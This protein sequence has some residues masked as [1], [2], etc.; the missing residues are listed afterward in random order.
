MA[1]TAMLQNGVPVANGTV[2][3]SRRNSQF[4]SGNVV[5]NLNLVDWR[6]P[7]SASNATLAFNEDII[8]RVTGHD[9]DGVLNYRKL[10]HASYAV[11]TPDHFMPLPAILG[12]ADG[13]DAEV[14]N[15][16]CNLGSIAMTGFLFA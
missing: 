6:N 4:G 1:R 15:N 13:D 3:H 16:I 2:G 7:K 11:P 5:H 9:E 10:Q 8:S 12:A 14:F